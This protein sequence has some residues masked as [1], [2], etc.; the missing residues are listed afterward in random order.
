MEFDKIF[1]T[2]SIQNN[3]SSS[4]FVLRNLKH[5]KAFDYYATLPVSKMSLIVAFV[6]RSTLLSIP[7]M[8]IIFLVGSLF[9]QIPIHIHPIIVLIIILGGYSLLR[10]LIY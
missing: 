9:F 1:D 6:T 7:S 5:Y 8:V 2:Y 3:L 10:I 4:G